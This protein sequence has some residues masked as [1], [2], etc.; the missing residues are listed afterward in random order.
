MGSSSTTRKAPRGSGPAAGRQHVLCLQI[1]RRGE[2]AGCSHAAA[3]RGG[4]AGSAARD[5]RGSSAARLQT[6]ALGE[7]SLLPAKINPC[8]SQEGRSLVL[9]WRG[10]TAL[11]SHAQFNCP[12]LLQMLFRNPIAAAKKC[13]LGLSDACAARP[14]HAPGQ[15]RDPKAGV[16]PVSLPAGTVRVSWRE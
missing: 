2:Q 9:R 4:D 5:A 3:R 8:D 10:A 15:L 7:A 14:D 13:A 12:V 1:P 11:A 6:W 16:F